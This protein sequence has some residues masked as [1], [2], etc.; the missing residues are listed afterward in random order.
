VLAQQR[1][2]GL[3][4]CFERGNVINGSS[5]PEYDRCISPESAQL[6][7]FHRRSLELR[8][9]FV[10]VQLEDISRYYTRIVRRKRRTR[11]E[12]R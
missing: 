5:I 6:R 2:A 4:C 8:A 3:D 9:E 1:V 7:A 10:D 12:L 11:I